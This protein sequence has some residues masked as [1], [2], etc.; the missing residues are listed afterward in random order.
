M[1]FKGYKLTFKFNAAHSNIENK[2]ENLHFHTFS[3]VF[4]LNTVKE[5]GESFSDIEKSIREWLHPY[6]DVYL[7]ETDTFKGRSTTIESIADTFYD[8]FNPRLLKLGFD[9]I[10]LDIFENPIR[11][12]SVSDRLLDADVNELEAFPYSFS[13]NVEYEAKMEEKT[14]ADLPKEEIE[15]INEKAAMWDESDLI[16]ITEDG[17][18]ADGAHLREEVEEL[19]GAISDKRKIPL[20]ILYAGIMLGLSWLLY[21]YAGNCSVYPKGTDAYAH[22]Y[23]GDII[24]NALKAHNPI[25]LIDPYWYNGFTIFRYN[26]PVFLYVFAFLEWVTQGSIYTAYLLFMSVCFLLGSIAFVIMGY[27]ENKVTLGAFLGVLWFFSPVNAGIFFNEG[28]LPL[29]LFNALLPFVILSV[30][31]AVRKGGYEPFIRIAFLSVLSVLT[32]PGAALISGVVISFYLFI[33]KLVYRKK[34]KRAGFVIGSYFTGFLLSGIWIVP[35]ILGNGTA[36][37]NDRMMAKYF[38]SIVTSLD[39]N[40]LIKDTGA[41]Y[42]GLSVFII[43]ILGLVLGTKEVLPGFITFIVIFALTG[44]SS[45]V[46]LSNVPLSSIFWMIRFVPCALAIFFAAFLSWRNL[47]KYILLLMCLILCADGV[48]CLKYIDDKKDD[49]APYERDERR[50]E[51]LYINTAKSEAKQRMAIMDGGDNGAFVPYYVASQGKKVNY[52]YGVDGQNAETALNTSMID[53]ALEL[54]W[55]DYVFDRLLET[56]TD[57]VVIPVEL[58]AHGRRDSDEI[59]N[60]GI[61]N[62]YEV[63]K[64]SEKALVMSADTPKQ[65]GVKTTYH[66]IAIGHAAKTLSFVYPSFEEGFSDNINDYDFKKLKSYD[67]IYLSDFVYEDKDSAEA[68]LNELADAGVKIFIDM[69]KIPKNP[70]TNV[71]EFMG[72]STQTFMYSGSF[73]VIIYGGRGYKCASFPDQY[74]QWKGNYLIGLKGETGYGSLNQKKLSFCGHNGNEN[75]TF[76]GF[77]FCYYVEETADSA[78]L[79]LLDEIIGVKSGMLPEREIVPIEV[80]YDNNTISIKSPESGV[81]TTIADIKDMYDADRAYTNSSHFVTVSEGNTKIRITYPYL[82]SGSFVSILGFL[83]LV[84]ILKKANRKK[85]RLLL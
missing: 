4:Y 45:Y 7:P 73:P 16:E 59:I 25:P 69:N 83:V 10:R 48:L 65:F 55:Y 81:N 72:V 46:I 82:I 84:S 12:Y 5:D 39:P 36:K 34:V 6:E 52:L 76:L 75:I 85:S 63:V 61:R 18:K 44:V 21:Y 60:A 50:A 29:A 26:G 53:S 40:V 17:E 41:F 71:F 66:N 67:I 37:I 19:R 78:A 3:L 24:Y 49:L 15:K 27:R 54:G 35:F 43:C 38:Q 62:G 80:K 56:G 31:D 77:N 23:R 74:Y 57:T 2:A 13:S 14:M 33:S 28:N 58:M 11:T 1:S 8:M 9:L 51:S 79:I 64:S 32:H 30:R 20:V 70:K 47:K 68:L 22:L 42:V